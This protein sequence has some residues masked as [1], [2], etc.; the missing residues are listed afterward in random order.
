RDD[1]I[2]DVLVQM[3]RQGRRAVE[4]R[5]AGLVQ[6]SA[7][8]GRR[9]SAGHG[10][11]EGAGPL[12]ADLV[13]CFRVAH[14]D[15]A[16]DRVHRHVEEHR[17]DAREGARL[18]RR[19]RRRIDREHVL[20]RQRE[21]HRGAPVPSEP[22]LPPAAR[23]VEP[24]DEAGLG[25]GGALEVPVGRRQPARHNAAVGE[26]TGRGR[27]AAVAD[28]TLG[29]ARRLVAGVED[30][31]VRVT[32]GGTEATS[33]MLTLSE[34]WFTT[35][36]SPFERAATATGSRPTGTEPA[37]VSPPADTAKISSR[38][39]GVL[40][41]NSRLPSGESA[42]GRT[43]PLSKVTNEAPSG[44][45]AARSSASRAGRPR[46]SGPGSIETPLGGVEGYHA[47]LLAR[48]LFFAS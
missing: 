39:S 47:R 48:Q 38:S 36:T 7:H 8:G 32:R 27:G 1:R 43:W 16:A 46:P 29:E 3:S 5:D 12:E 14:V 6:V 44:G 4:H 45:A 21:A 28:E 15:L 10:R 35:Q 33:T 34:R 31:S 20:V 17:A 19:V 9:G 30:S 18:G 11:G 40:T 25:S 24:D 37:C 13:P 2:V 42:S 22:I 23:R 41:A 26:G